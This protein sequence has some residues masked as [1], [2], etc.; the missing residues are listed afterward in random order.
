MKVSM[1]R[2]ILSS[3]IVP[4]LIAERL[5]IWGSTI[6]TQRVRQRLAAEQLCARIGISRATL[7]RL[8]RGDPAVSVAGY[9]SAFLVLGLL[10]QAMPPLDA[11]LWSAHEHGR[12]RARQEE[13]ADDYF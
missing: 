8:E 11:A 3:A 4:S 5:H 1:P 6:R 7:S 2:K 12:V 13:S 9:L 10:D